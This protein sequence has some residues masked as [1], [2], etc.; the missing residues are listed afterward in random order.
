MRATHSL[1]PKPITQCHA[2][3]V[4]ARAAEM[5]RSLLSLPTTM[6]DQ[7]PLM[8]SVQGHA[9]FTAPLGLQIIALALIMATCFFSITNRRDGLH[10]L[11]LC[12]SEYC[13]SSFLS[14]TR[15]PGGPPLLHSGGRD[16]V[17]CKFILICGDADNT[18]TLFDGHSSTGQTS[19]YHDGSYR[20][21]YG[22]SIFVKRCSIV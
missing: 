18:H 19:R 9:Y 5:Q 13:S 12:L 7:S 21:R 22:S 16:G 4:E 17:Y 8:Q 15:F 6:Q 1:M 14:I 2:E 10:S 20:N 11:A 3:P